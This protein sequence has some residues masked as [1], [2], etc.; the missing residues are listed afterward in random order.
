MFLKEMRNFI[1]RFIISRFGVSSNKNLSKKTY[2]GDLE[3]SYLGGS[4]SICEEIF[5][6]NK[7]GE[8]ISKDDV[9]ARLHIIYLECFNEFHKKYGYKVVDR[10]TLEK[11]INLSEVQNDREI[12]FC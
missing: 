9:I 4:L 6:L 11:P 7:S 12:T 10:A 2:L 3:C 1:F 8:F 5:S